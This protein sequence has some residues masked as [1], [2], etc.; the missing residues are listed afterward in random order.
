M[1]I[2]TPTKLLQMVVALL[3]LGAGGCAGDLEDADVYR[4]SVSISTSPRIVNNPE[5]TTVGELPSPPNNNN[6]AGAGGQNTGGYDTGGASGE[7]GSNDAGPT[8]GVPGLSPAEQQL[9]SCGDVPKEIFGVVGKCGS[10]ACHG[11]SDAAPVAYSDLGHS[12]DDVTT[13]LVDMPG[14][15][16]CASYKMIDAE[17]PEDS[18][19]LTKLTDS[20]P[21]GQKMPFGGMISAAE[22][23]C[24]LA[25]TRVIIEGL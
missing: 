25:W 3:P 15:G 4:E 17:H 5:S 12:T 20:P 13:R 10:A 14:T 11:S 2:R 22:R 24:I 23:D 16:A 8:G 7:S 6:D 21:C 1:S 18:L 19:M 9:M